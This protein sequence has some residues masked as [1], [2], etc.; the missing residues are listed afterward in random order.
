MQNA[1]RFR[2]SLEALYL[3]SL[4]SQPLVP[5]IADDGS[6]SLPERETDPSDVAKEIVTEVI[7]SHASLESKFAALEELLEIVAEVVPSETTF[8]RYAAEALE[9]FSPKFFGSKHPINSFTLAPSNTNRK[10]ATEAIDNKVI[11]IISGIV[12]AL[13]ALIMK[14][15]SWGK[16]KGEAISSKVETVKVPI[17]PKVA[18]VISKGPATALA[19][20]EATHTDQN[21]SRKWTLNDI[22]KTIMETVWGEVSAKGNNLDLSLLM[23]ALKNGGR[24]GPRLNMYTELN[25]AIY[26]WNMTASGLYTQTS[27][28]HSGVLPGFLRSL[29]DI[30]L[31]TQSINI[32][33]E[34]AI[35]GLHVT[36]FT[37]LSESVEQITKK[38][39]STGIKFDFNNLP[40]VPAWDEENSAES[41]KAARDSVMQFLDWL[42]LN[43]TQMLEGENEALTVR[44]LPSDLCE[45]VD[46]YDEKVIQA[47]DSKAFNVADWAKYTEKAYLDKVNGQLKGFEQQVEKAIVGFLVTKDN[48]EH[49]YPAAV[50]IIPA[51]K[52]AI[53]VHSAMIQV[54][55]YYVSTITT[56]I[57]SFV[58][59]RDFFVPR[60]K[61]A[62]EAQMKALKDEG[63]LEE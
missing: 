44:D 12:L 22:Y 23:E 5:I 2:A 46:Q 45:N 24:G 60:L 63:K 39:K 15:G 47:A 25:K 16:A 58:M 48:G 55:S 33:I 40:Q 31:G 18:E 37:M 53:S 3:P 54:I 32:E 13:I 6:V 38:L 43:Q 35:T 17:D 14:F 61:A 59:W 8:N 21:G 9:A 29:K 36:A 27:G 52:T 62:T 50:K 4:S 1:H 26:L 41:A 30:E 51:V 11:G 19:D 57:N 56:G 10:V 7:D 28:R 20:M 49:Y 42:R 34:T